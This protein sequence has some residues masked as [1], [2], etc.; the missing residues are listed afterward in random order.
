[1]SMEVLLR[2]FFEEQIH[3][4]LGDGTEIEGGV[5]IG[6]TEFLPVKALRDDSD[7]YSVEFDLWLN[8]VWRPQQ[9]ERRKEILAL[10]VNSKRYADLSAAVRR[11]QVIPFIGSGM[12]VASG[13]P[14]WSDLLRR[15]RRFTTCDP[16]ALEA[17]LCS[18]SF[19]EAADLLASA[20]N[21]RLLAERIEHD[22]R[23]DD[24][25]VIS[26]A[27]R[28][29]PG[30][31]YNLI[32][33]TNLDDVLEHIYRSCERPFTYVLPGR[34]LVRYRSLKNPALRFLLKLHGDC[35][36]TE[37]RVLLSKEYDAAYAAGST[38]R[39]ELTLMYRLNSLL[40]LGCSLGS[41]RTVR[42][43]EEVAS[44]DARMPKH[45]AFLALPDGEAIRVEREN[46]LTDRGIYPIWY[47][48]PHDE[49]LTAL[50][51]GLFIE[52]TGRGR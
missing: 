37:S 35:R 26:G 3:F 20:T 21:H 45:F 49:A 50:L 46:W 52:P 43:V 9:Q 33:T 22:L 19:E 27:V 31:F 30:L 18:F 14:T 16:A 5:F 51:D 17:L 11:Q 39:E 40:F 2:S 34:E 6:S 13:L 48:L 44:C 15:V 29:L 28:L 7:A 38:I 12:S 47:S 41:D 23:V 8:E 10:Q 36:M 32:I 1:M 25:A 42:L 4:Q 24:P